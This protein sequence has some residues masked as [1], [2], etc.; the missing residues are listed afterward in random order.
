MN[1]PVRPRGLLLP[2][3]PAHAVLPRPLSAVQATK[4]AIA[5]HSLQSASESSET[6]S[7][8]SLNGPMDP[9]T[10]RVFAT[11]DGGGGGGLSGGAIA[12]KSP[13]QITSHHTVSHRITWHLAHGT[14]DRMQVRVNE[15]TSNTLVGIIIAVLIILALASLLLFRARRNGPYIGPVKPAPAPPYPEPYLPQYTGPRFAS[16][17]SPL[18]GVSMPQA[19]H[20]GG[21][22]KGYYG[23]PQRGGGVRFGEVGV[24]T[25]ER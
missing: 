2:T 3:C 15:L 5:D 12:G 10:M 4:S 20:L 7:T 21:V 13:L 1:L 17:P 19:V 14:S 6:G 22:G 18:P 24:R 25:Y 23:A 9:G 8:S 16:R 11:R